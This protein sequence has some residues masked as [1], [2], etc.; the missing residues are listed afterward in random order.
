VAISIWADK[1][2]DGARAELG[3]RLQVEA[4]ARRAIQGALQRTQDS[5]GMLKPVNRLAELLLDSLLFQQALQVTD[6]AIEREE[7]QNGRAWSDGDSQ[8][9]WILDNRAAALY[10]LGRWPAAVTQLE[11]ASHVKSGFDVVSQVINLAGVYNEMRRPREARETLQR[12]SVREASSYGVMQFQLQ[13]LWSAVQLHDQPDA[14]L[15]RGYL[16]EHQNDAP[17][18]YQRALL[19]ADRPEEGAALLISRLVDV[20]RRSAALEAV[21]YYTKTPEPPLVIENHRRWRALI[22]RPDVR[23]AITRVGRVDHY[24]LRGG[25]Y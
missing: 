4:V 21:Q 10:G 6:A 14:K 9:V 20:R 5:P 2:F 7:I 13:K 24:A 18:A 1:R 23:Q 3:E 12:M 22:D 8:Y 11:A 25:G 17:D 16:R 15:A 19:I